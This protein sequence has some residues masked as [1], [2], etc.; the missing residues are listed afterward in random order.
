MRRPGINQPL[1]VEGLSQDCL[2][3]GDLCK[4]GALKDHWTTFLPRGSLRWPAI[5]KIRAARYLVQIELHNQTLPQQIRISW[6]PCHLGGWRSWMHCPYCE[7]RVAKLLKGIGGY[8]CRTCLGNPLYASQAKSSHGRRHFELCKIRLLLNGNASPLEPF[9][10]RPRG[11]HRKTYDRL[12]ARALRLEMDLPRKLR[13][14][15]V[16]YKNLIYYLS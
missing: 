7:K 9:P 8:F 14:K 16:D 1:T 12:K 13:G 11:M 6:T 5:R 2:R 4:I 15:V 3:V 10:E